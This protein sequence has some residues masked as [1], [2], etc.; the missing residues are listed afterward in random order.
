MRNTIKWFMIILLSAIG[1]FAHF[2][3]ASDKAKVIGW[4]TLQ[5]LD[6]RTGEMTPKLKSLQG[7]I[8]RLPGYIVPLDGNENQIITKFL[9]VPTLGA[10]THVPP[11]PP[12]QTVYVEM[13]E[14]VSTNMLYSPVWVSGQLRFSMNQYKVEGTDYA[15]EASYELTGI[16]VKSYELL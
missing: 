2:A 7:E 13:S 3:G 5:G 9:L 8:I 1:G 14:G 15:P 10:C 6:Y 16:E 4:R 12:N 11:P